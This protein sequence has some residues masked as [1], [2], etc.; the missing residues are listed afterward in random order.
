[1][2]G[3]WDL[4]VDTLN[5]RENGINAVIVF[6]DLLLISLAR[7]KKFRIVTENQRKEWRKL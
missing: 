6:E 3:S 7:K 5:V 4:G 1:M 2:S